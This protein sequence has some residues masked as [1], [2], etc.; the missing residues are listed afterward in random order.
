MDLPVFQLQTP[1]PQCFPES[2]RHDSPHHHLDRTPDP[3]IIADFFGYPPAFTQQFA[4]AADAAFERQAGRAMHILSLPP[5]N[6]FAPTPFGRRQEAGSNQKRLHPQFSPGRPELNSYPSPPMSDSHSPHRRSVQLVEQEGHHHPYPPPLGEPRRLEGLPPPPPP[7]FGHHPTTSSHGLQ[8][9]RPLYPGDAHHGP[10]PVQFQPGRAIEPPTYGSGHMAQN[11][12]YGYPPSSVPPFYGAQGPGPQ[13]QSAAIIAPPPLRASKP[14]RR[15]KAHVASACVNCKKAHLS[16]DVQRPCGRCVASGKQDTC[17][18]VQHKKRGRPRL[19]DD[20]DF[21]R[22]EEGRPPPTQLLGSLSSPAQD[23]YGQQSPFQSQHRTTDPLRT[24]QRT[25]GSS[26]DLSTAHSQQSVGGHASNVAAYNATPSSP[27]ASGPNASYQ[28]LPVAFLNLDL[29][30]LKSNQAFQDL[31]SFLGD[32]RG[33]NLSDLLEA[34]QLDVLHRMR[35]ELREERDE[36]EPAYMAPITP[37]GQNPLDTIAERDVDQ[38]SQGYTKRPFLLNFRLPNGQH[39]S[40][41]TQIRLAKTSLYFVTLVVHTPP[42]STG[43]ALLTQQL[44]PTT[45]LHASHSP[46]AAAVTPRG[47]Y[48]P[49][50]IRPASS[51]SSAPTSPYFSLNTVRT[52]LPA[53]GSSGYGNSP[54][55]NYSPTAGPDQGYFPTIQPPSQ[56]SGYPSPYPPPISRSGSLASVPMRESNQSSRL[57]GLQLPPIRTTSTQ[58]LQSPRLAEASDASRVRPRDSPISA[59]RPDTPETGKR[60]RLNLQEVL[61]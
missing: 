39:Q 18:D 21:G 20:K 32:T 23:T 36:R 28:S 34:R 10:Q 24:I 60:R 52:S 59:E 8:H 25:G 47:E 51:A 30:V 4:P 7:S 29:V 41:Q 38:V 14:A 40:L 44:A 12:G 17:K 16:C 56:P 11:Y 45:P 57:E 15:T 48:G 43:P 26:E 50:P 27:Y 61:H 1:E 53:I 37:I 5:P 13:G 54:S 19:R 31:V 49:P 3:S 9:Q 46:S 22:A 55:Y 6:S 33:K 58:A 35:N 2:T 42:R